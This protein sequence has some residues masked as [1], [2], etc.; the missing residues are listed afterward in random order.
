MA[1]AT[2]AGSRLEAPSGRA[3]APPTPSALSSRPTHPSAQ[4][5]IEVGLDVFV[6]ETEPFQKNGNERSSIPNS[7]LHTPLLRKKLK[8]DWMFL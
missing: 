5:K 3:R 2:V 6:N 8:S 4:K 7:A 1:S